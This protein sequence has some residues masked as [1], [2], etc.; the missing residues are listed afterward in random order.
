MFGF[1]VWI[2]EN[3]NMRCSYCYENGK[4]DR[5]L[6]MSIEMLNETIDF[7][8][9][10]AK[11]QPKDVVIINIHGGE[12]LLDFDKVVYF[13]EHSRQKLAN[14]NVLYNIIT[15][16]TLLDA[17][18]AKWLNEFMNS[19]SI[20]LDGNANM[21]DLNRKYING[22]GTY[23]DIIRNINECKIDKNK[24]RVRMTV[25]S[26]NVENLSYSI[27]H[28]LELGFRMIV[29]GIAYEDKNWDNKK[30]KFLENELMKVKSRYISRTDVMIAMTNKSEI[31]QKGLCSGGITKFD[32][33]PNG[34]IYPC[35]YVCGL[36][37]YRLG[38]ICEKSPINT[39]QLKN[40][41]STNNSACNGCTYIKYC[42]A[43][44]CKYLNKLNSGDYHLPSELMCQI[45]N[46]KYRVCSS[47]TG[48]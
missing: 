3:C 17:E 27:S 44:R 41:Y 31:K 43:T 36:K 2:T 39:D 11:Q 18:K 48:I 33:L 45:E 35:S 25:N 9:T 16:G 22:N 34:D 1:N 8:W 30:I 32:I 19:I 6:H 40:L 23:A 14:Y 38:N 7:I 26:K 20:S 46:V 37:Q 24:I 28:I 21:H 47:M 4:N 12:P 13:V 10:K 15:N 29:P 42:L 5:A